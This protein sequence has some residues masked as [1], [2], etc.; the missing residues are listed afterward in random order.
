MVNLCTVD[1]SKAFDKVNHHALYIKLTRNAWQSLGYLVAMVKSLETL[2]NEVQ[3][4][5]LHVERFHMVKRLRKSV[6]YVRRYSTKCASFLVSH[7]G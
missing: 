5:H 4:H 2:E 1:L 6:Q 3:I 7:R